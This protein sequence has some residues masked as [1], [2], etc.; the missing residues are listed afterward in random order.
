MDENALHHVGRDEAPSFADRV[1]LARRVMSECDETKSEPIVSFACGNGMGRPHPHV[2]A[3]ATKSMLHGDGRSF[4]DYHTFEDNDR[5][6]DLIREEFT[7]RGVRDSIAKNICI[8][9]GTTSL[10]CSY[11]HTNKDEISLVLAPRGYY[12]EIPVWCERF[13]AP[14]AMIPTTSD[15]SYKI[16][17]HHLESE[18]KT[19]IN[20]ASK[21]GRVV[22]ILANPTLMGAIYSEAELD[23]LAN[24]MSEYRIDVIYDIVY[25]DT[26]FDHRSH[27]VCAFARNNDLANKT[28]TLRSPSKAY[29]LANIRVGWAC[30]PEDVIR[31][32]NLYRELTMGSVPFLMQALAKGALEAPADFLEAYRLECRGRV[33]LVKSLLERINRGLFQ[34]FGVPF[35]DTLR[36]ALEPLAG[37]SILL[38]A[39]RLKGLYTPEGTQIDTSLDLTSFFLRHARV[40]ISPGYSIGFDGLEFRLAFGSVGHRHTYKEVAEMERTYVMHVLQREHGE[41]NTERLIPVEGFRRGREIIEQVFMDRIFPCIYKLVSSNVPS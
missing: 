6:L 34:R 11:L 20:T 17:P 24:A 13:E 18:I 33:S 4:E 32:M 27:S 37:H 5:L 16:S 31:R 38:S 25:A 1:R 22:I 3:T 35:N 40:R 19:K 23:D 30:G 39:E 26:E 14:F 7:T 8:D 10:F 21:I 41:V 12:H 28:V 2:L 9:A 15:N 36:V 29:N